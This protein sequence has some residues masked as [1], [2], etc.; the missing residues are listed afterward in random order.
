MEREYPIAILE[1]GGDP[2]K[3]IKYIM[4]T[5]VPKTWTAVSCMTRFLFLI[6]QYIRLLIPKITAKSPANSEI[7][8]TKYVSYNCASAEY[9]FLYKAI[10]KTMA[11]VKHKG[12]NGLSAIIFLIIYKQIDL[13]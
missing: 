7:G 9:P 8:T 13:V 4:I 3:H 12:K 6:S 5:M 11:M 2:K 1:F 10:S